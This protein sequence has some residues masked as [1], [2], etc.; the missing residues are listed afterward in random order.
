MKKTGRY[1][2]VINDGPPVN[3]HKPS[4]DVMLRSLLEC[5][6]KDVLAVMLT[7]MGSDGAQGMLELQQAGVKTTA[8]DEA[9]SVVWGMPGSA[10][11]LSAAQSIV[12]L[13]KMASHVI[14][15]YE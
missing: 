8:Q 9:S 12:S 11:K 14:G 10:V 3:R 6:P 13:N 4:V 2:C 5:S 1:T 15:Q 7:G